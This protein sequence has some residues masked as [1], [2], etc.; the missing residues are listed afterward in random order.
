M[1]RII[2][3]NMKLVFLIGSGLF[4][5]VVLLPGPVAGQEVKRGTGLDSGNYR[6]DETEI[7]GEL[8]DILGTMRLR[9]SEIVGSL[10]R[11]RLS[12]SLP[13]KDAELSLVPDEGPEL[14]LLGD[15][16]PFIDPNRFENEVFTPEPGTF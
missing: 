10:E 1:R 5:L 3:W 13:W 9:E 7:R 16:Y 15:S 8:K 4:L 2:S 11:P 14:D 12:Y 6:L